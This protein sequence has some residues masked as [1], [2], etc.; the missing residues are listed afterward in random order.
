MLNKDQK[1][2]II[3]GIGLSALFAG[4]SFF[5]MPSLAMRFFGMNREASEQAGSKL[6][7]RVIGIRDFAF[8]LM[9]WLNRDDPKARQPWIKTFGY[10][11]CGDS[12]AALLVLR[13]PHAGFFT[14][15]GG[16]V[17]SFVLG[18]LAWLTHK[19]EE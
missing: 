4:V 16:V 6:A 9:L 5:L 10:C 8:G 11:L 1:K 12:L 15:A 17:L 13:K 2:L 18:T 7:G 19:D 14:F 3:D